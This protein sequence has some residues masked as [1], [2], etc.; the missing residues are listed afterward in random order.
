VLGASQDFAEVFPRQMRTD[1]EQPRQVQLARGDSVEQLRKFSDERRP[2]A[3]TRR[4]RERT[5][6]A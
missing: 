3:V 6:R 5:P 4:F 1:H 2:H